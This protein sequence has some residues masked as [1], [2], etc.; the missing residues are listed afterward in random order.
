[1]ASWI[2]TIDGPSGAGKTTAAR[3]LAARL[4]CDYLDT[5]AGYRVAALALQRAGIPVEADDERIRQHLL[6]LRIE[7]KGPA[8]LLDGEDVSGPIREPAVAQAASR[9]AERPVVR[10]FLKGWQ[11]QW[12]SGRRV[13]TEGRDQGTT[14]FP[15]ALCKFFLEAAPEERVER[16]FREL[17]SRG[18]PISRE[19]VRS[20]QQERDLRDS[21]RAIDRLEPAP[22]AIRIDST[23]LTVEAVVDLMAAH[24]AQRLRQLSPP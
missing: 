23:P 6:S 20:S 8:A 18:I 11:R 16:R 14:V 5:G 4:G 12:A 22:D 19:Q 1:V 13:V 21:T 15:G 9:L 17:Q 24:V 3:L 2:V 10:E 7:L